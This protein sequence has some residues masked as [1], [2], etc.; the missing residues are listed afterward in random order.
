MTFAHLLIGVFFSVQSSFFAH[1]MCFEV[2]AL[3][4]TGGPAI[5]KKGAKDRDDDDDDL[6]IMDPDGNDMKPGTLT[7][8]PFLCTLIGI[9]IRLLIVMSIYSFRQW[10]LRVGNTK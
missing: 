8:P 3:V 6:G 9:V 4:P 7:P 10:H 2:P 1:F 5:N